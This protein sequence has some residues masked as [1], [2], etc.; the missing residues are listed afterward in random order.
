[1]NEVMQS[2]LVDA[3]RREILLLR[4]W[5]SESLIGSWSTHQ[6]NPM[7]QRADELESLL[8]RLRCNPYQ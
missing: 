2:E 8:L 1:M 4:K 3:I 5:A 6:V 7:R